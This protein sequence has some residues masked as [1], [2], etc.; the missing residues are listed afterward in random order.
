[1]TV[2]ATKN[3]TN[4]TVVIANDDDTNT[5]HTAD[6]ALSVGVNTL[7]VLVTAEN[8]AT[9]KT[10]T[11]TLTRVALTVPDAPTDLMATANGTSDI[12]LEWNEPAYNGG[13]IITGYKIQHS[14]AGNSPGPS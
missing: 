12:N 1:M 8:T 10:Y 13:T 4:A 11:V 9:T 3:H 7:T 5:A 2:T 6:L 14:P